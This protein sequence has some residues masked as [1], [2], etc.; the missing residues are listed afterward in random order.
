MAESDFVTPIKPVKR[1]WPSRDSTNVSVS[2]PL[3]KEPKTLT[4]PPSPFLKQL[5]YGT[6]INVYLMQQPATPSGR[7]KSPWAVKKLSSLVNK[8]PNGLKTYETRLAYEANILKGLDH[9]NIVGY[10][11]AVRGDDGRLCLCMESGEKSLN[12]LIEL[13]QEEGEPFPPNKIHKVVYAASSALDYLHNNKKLLHGDIK[14]H[15]IL[16]K[17]DFAEIKLCDFGVCMK[18]KEDLQGLADDSDEYVGTSAYTSSEVLSGGLIT[19]KADIYSLGCVIYEMLSLTM[20]HMPHML[21][22]S[23]LSFDESAF[24]EAL[25]TVPAL[26]DMSYDKLLHPYIALMMICCREDAERRPAAREIC[27]TLQQLVEKPGLLE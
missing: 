9:P 19:D 8:S 22:D 21:D 12:Q 27:E 23:E 11:D 14:S 20:P 13:R 17:G 10:R 15:N 6:G 2:T 25:G 4:I 5:G 7:V 18:L 26:P 24:S 1:K 16:V 3:N